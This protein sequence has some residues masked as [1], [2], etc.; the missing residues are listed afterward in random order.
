MRE[1]GEAERGMLCPT[2]RTPVSERFR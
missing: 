2:G 1:V